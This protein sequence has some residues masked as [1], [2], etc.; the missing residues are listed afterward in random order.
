MPRRPPH[1]SAVAALGLVLGACGGGA[2]E[3]QPAAP[4]DST[5]SAGGGTAPAAPTAT[6]AGPLAFAAPTIGGGEFDAS[7]LRGQPA[8]VWFWAPW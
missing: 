4:R 1:W 8:L 6:D 5:A 3:P 2:S 7:S